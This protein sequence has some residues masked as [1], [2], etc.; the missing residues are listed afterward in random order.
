MNRQPS[1]GNVGPKQRLRTDGSN[2]QMIDSTTAQRPPDCRWQKRGALAQEIDRSRG[3][4]TTKIHAVIDCLGRLIAFEVTPGQLGDVRAAEALPAAGKCFAA[5]AY[6]GDAHS[7][8]LT[9]RG[10]SR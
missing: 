4:R 10:T 9:E 2:T 1:L 5:T 8:F 3:E 6:D 7:R